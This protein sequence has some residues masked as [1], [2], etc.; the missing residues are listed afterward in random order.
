MSASIRL[1]LTD[2]VARPAECH[3]AGSHDG[4]VPKGTFYV[5]IENV[6]VKNP[7]QILA[8][9]GTGVPGYVIRSSQGG[10][11]KNGRVGARAGC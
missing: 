10:A 9:G 3:T 5:Q 7:A 6:A 1:R 4:F 2:Q 8:L 11:C